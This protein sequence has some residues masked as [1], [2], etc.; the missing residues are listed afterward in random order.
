MK[1]NSWKE[2]IDLEGMLPELPNGIIRNSSKQT[3]TVPIENI[4]KENLTLKKELIEYINF[5]QVA[6]S[7]LIQ[8]GEIVST[9]GL[10]SVKNILSVTEQL[11]KKYGDK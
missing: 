9:T 1:R 5:V 11:Q 10:E 8:D 4:I 6:A 2:Y 7:H 3:D